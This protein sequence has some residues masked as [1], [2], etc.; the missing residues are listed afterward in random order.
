MSIG[1]AG[2]GA[3]AR[4][5]TFETN[6][7]ASIP[8]RDNSRDPAHRRLLLAL[9]EEEHLKQAVD[10]PEALQLLSADQ[11]KIWKKKFGGF[12]LEELNS[13]YQEKDP[14]LF[15]HGLLLFGSRLEQRD[16]WDGAASTYLLIGEALSAKPSA[17]NNFSSP[18]LLKIQTQAQERLNAILGRGAVGPRL[19]FLIGRFL[20]EITDPAPIV[21]MGL[22]GTVF[23]LGKLASLSHLHSNPSL[24]FFTRGGGAKALANVAGF[25]LEVPTFTFATKGVEAALGKK[26]SLEKI[27]NELAS[28][29]LFLGP[30]KFMA[31][32]SASLF[33]R[34]HRINPLGSSPHSM[35]ILTKASQIIFPQAGMLAGILMGHRLEEI[36]GLKKAQ[37]GATTL[38]DA[39][40]SLLHFNV[41]GH[42]TRRAFGE[43]FHAFERLLEIQAHL[44]TRPAG[45]PFEILAAGSAQFSEWLSMVQ[46]AKALATGNPPSPH[47]SEKDLKTLS[48]DWMFSAP[49][50]TPGQ[51]KALE[52]K[53]RGRFP[54][55]AKHYFPEE[56]L[57]AVFCTP[58]EIRGFHERLLEAFTAVSNRGSQT[59]FYTARAIEFAF[60]YDAANTSTGS[61]DNALLQRVIEHV[62]AEASPHYLERMAEVFQAMEAG[63]SRRALE[64]MATRFGALEGLKI[65]ADPV[66]PAAFWRKRSP[67][68]SSFFDG[69]SEEH[70]VALLNALYLAAEGDRT[71]AKKML[72]LLVESTDSEAFNYDELR[73]AI[74]YAIEHPAGM[75]VIRRI[76]NVLAVGD[77]PAKIAELTS[78]QEVPDTFLTI[79][80]FKEQGLSLEKIAERINDTA[81]T[82]FIEDMR[83]ARKL[84]AVSLDIHPAIVQPELRKPNFKKL[85]QAF[86]AIVRGKGSFS[87][88]ELINLL[89]LHPNTT[90]TALK[91]FWRSGKFRIEMPS[92]EEFDKTVAKWK[93]SPDCKEAIF[94][95]QIL[96][97]PRKR[98]LLRALPSIDTSSSPGLNQLLNSVISRLTGLVHEF[99]HWHH[100]IGR[101]EPAAKNFGRI[102]FGNPSREERLISETMSF[103]EEQ[104]WYIPMVADDY[105]QI[106]HRLGENLAMY[107]RN[108]ADKAYFGKVNRKGKFK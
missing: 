69:F 24:N 52:Q 72:G 70:G 85:D 43:G 58:C 13:L 64:T 82:A 99:E 77:I 94:I 51:G 60:G 97:W 87:P 31:W 74:L 104:R 5:S 38:T 81:H 65:P 96:P 68:V 23:K 79:L 56:I 35:G 21:A 3:F 36:A 37:A 86:L 50:P 10:F 71:L 63:L 106:S 33:N 67:K 18:S 89:Q 12:A 19:E 54:P 48:L 20:H 45:S 107:Y 76:L 25:L 40:V 102:P 11:L 91:D 95:N 44:L 2:R 26:T 15:F 55:R 39:L 92:G 80:S 6:F 75:L 16:L 17:K 83:L 105:L 46:P 29:A 98:I 30:L 88:E 66:F 9:F 73:S 41:A 84:V 7:S 100:F 47:H 53:F 59:Q 78:A 61:F 57:N 4:P 32:G 34:I 42:L 90:V 8:A 49:F 1:I 93:G 108:F 28:G 62:L 103:L 14:A 22:A 101:P 27:S